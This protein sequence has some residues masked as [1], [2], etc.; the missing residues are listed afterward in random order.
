MTEFLKPSPLGVGGSTDTKS[1]VSSVTKAIMQP[2]INTVQDSAKDFVVNNIPEKLHTTLGA[3]YTL[4]KTALDQGYDFNIGKS[5]KLS[6]SWKDKLSIGYNL[7][8]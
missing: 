1:N 4:A 7:K 2:T 8:F 6:L 5:G 3:S